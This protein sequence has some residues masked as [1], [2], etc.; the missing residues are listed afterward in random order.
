MDNFIFFYLPM[1]IWIAISILFV[2]AAYLMKRSFMI[3]FSLAAFLV[4][5]LSFIRHTDTFFSQAIMFVCVSAVFLVFG[6]II[7]GK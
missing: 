2:A 4:A 5:L 6:K 1:I 3:C 7:F